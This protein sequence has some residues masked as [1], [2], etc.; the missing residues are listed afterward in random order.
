MTEALQDALRA[1]VR[2]GEGPPLRISE[3]AEVIGYS[4]PTVRKL[5]SEN[6]I[7]TVGLT[8]ERRIPVA[9]AA[10]IA[11]ALGILKK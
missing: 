8:D 4:V 1:R 9:E 2:K 5:I 3:M 11:T 10:R 7:Q 6:V